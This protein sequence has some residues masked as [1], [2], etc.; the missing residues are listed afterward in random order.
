MFSEVE[1]GIFDMTED[2]DNNN[3]RVASVRRFFDVIVVKDFTFC[4][5]PAA[6]VVDR[7]V[8]LMSSV[9]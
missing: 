2:D 8:V 4:F 3:G 9:D 6:V 1:R 7:R 5:L